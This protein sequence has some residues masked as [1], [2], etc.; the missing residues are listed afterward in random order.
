MCNN[1]ETR[2]SRMKSEIDLNMI[3]L[4]KVKMEEK[5][6]KNKCYRDLYD[7]EILRLLHLSK[8]L[9]NE[10]EKIRECHE[11]NIEKKE[12]YMYL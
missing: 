10:Q 5:Y 7:S 1:L 9:R 2:Y 4:E 6:Q 12:Y 3:R 8:S 11:E